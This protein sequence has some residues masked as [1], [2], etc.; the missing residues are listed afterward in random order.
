[1]YQIYPKNSAVYA[2]MS[3]RFIDDSRRRVTMFTAFDGGS[4]VIDNDIPYC[5]TVEV[6]SSRGA[7]LCDRIGT[8]IVYTGDFSANEREIV[9][10]YLEEQHAKFVENKPGTEY[11]FTTVL[12][13][14]TVSVWYDVIVP[15]PFV[16][17]DTETMEEVPLGPDTEFMLTTVP[18]S[19]KTTGTKR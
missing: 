7:T 2:V 17:L 8:E 9:E 3:L 16:V 15:G 6:V 10:W 4:Y 13:D 12:M 5:D 1:M 14:T 11:G 18:E 19:L